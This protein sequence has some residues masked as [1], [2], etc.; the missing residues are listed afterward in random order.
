MYIVLLK[1]TKLQHTDNIISLLEYL[2]SPNFFLRLYA[3]QLISHISDLRPERTQEC[4]FT[5]PLGIPRLVAVLDETR[6]PIRNEALLLLI[7]LTPSSQELQKL[8][9]FENA[10][11]RILSLI[12]NEG[13][14]THGSTVVSDCLSLLGNLLHLNS[15]NQTFFCE[16][17][18]ARRVALLLSNAIRPLSE[19]DEPLSQWE[20]QDR[21]KNIW[22][23]LAIVRLFLVKGGAGT[24]SNQQVFY[25]N[26][27]LHQSLCLAFSP[28]FSARVQI[29][30]L[31]TCADI[32]YGSTTTQE[33][34][35]DLTITVPGPKSSSENTTPVSAGG[36]RDTRKVNALEALLHILLGET[37]TKLKLGVRFAACECIKALFWENPGIRTQFLRR[38]VEG[39]THGP[40]QIPNIFSILL[41]PPAVRGNS[42][43]Y[44]TWFASVMLLHLISDDS[45]AKKYSCR[46]TEGD[47]SKGEEV[48]TCL[49]AITE[50]LVTGIE[51]DDDKRISAGY[52]M[53]LCVWLYEDPD[54]VN[55]FL[56][57]GSSIQSLLQEAKQTAASRSPILELCAVLLVI[58]YEFSTKESPIPRATLHE[59]MTGHLGRDQYASKITQFR[60]LEMVR[61]FEILPQT[62]EGDGLPGVY[63]ERRFIDFFKDN[64]NRLVRA[65][66]RDPSMEIPVLAN[67]VPKGISRELVESLQT[68]VAEGS[69]KIQDLESTVGL[70]RQ[71][72]EQE[73]AENKTTKESNASTLAN[74]TNA[75]EDKY[76]KELATLKADCQGAKDTADEAK[77]ARKRA[78]KELDDL[79]IVFEDLATK[80]K[81]EKVLSTRSIC[82]IVRTHQTDSY[83]RNDSK[84]LDNKSQK[85]KRMRT[86]Q[87][88]RKSKSWCVRREAL[89]VFTAPYQP[90]P[91][92]LQGQRDDRTLFAFAS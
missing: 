64:F 75:I 86:K 43:P 2:E 10:F 70:L 27:I 69:Q 41:T 66:D 55:D 18:G 3:L 52:I 88:G 68:Q 83:Y 59:L 65:I 34:F 57:E 78:E 50:N 46:I 73:Q 29:M 84:N 89:K 49:Q 79:L 31:N 22:G 8:V 87:T 13:G 48:V 85:T 9:A 42:D 77:A 6:E 5:A 20:L 17:G 19:Q 51:K 40:D 12:E 30:A 24:A 80:R 25:G 90:S 39:H 35:A 28:E 63:F 82:E 32:L 53:L 54:V 21:D 7:A 71:R 37:A 44:R 74:T 61:D 23:T 11:T 91:A 38:A 92:V 81:Q 56:G 45:E 1:L 67:G 62:A 60:Q 14:L 47:E 26:G 58:A 33:Q 4:I 72:L 36:K 76:Q 16:I 15:S